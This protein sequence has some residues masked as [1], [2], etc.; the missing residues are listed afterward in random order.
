LI[1][2]PP[3]GQ[4]YAIGCFGRKVSG[5][6][7]PAPFQETEGFIEGTN[8][9]SLNP[10]SL[11]IAQL[12]DRLGITGVSSDNKVQ[13][14]P[15]R[16]KIIGAFPNPFNPVTSISFEL[17]TAAFVKIIIYDSLGKEVQ[18]LSS[19]YKSPGKNR[20]T[21]NPASANLPSG[22]YF[23]RITAGKSV[24]MLKLLYLK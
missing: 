3:T 17:G 8:K 11:Y 9:D 23:C 12:K 24:T 21:W 2:K 6:T 16:L 4:N 20:V 22:I 13:S 7:P 19:E 1:Q 18:I 15:E 14:T 5:A 10:Q